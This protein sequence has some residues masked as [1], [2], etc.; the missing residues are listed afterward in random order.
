MRRNALL[1]LIFIAAPVLADFC[2]HT[3]P[4]QAEVAAGGIT[5]I[6]IKAEAGSLKVTG[7]PSLATIRARGTACAS[8]EGL[9]DKT[10]LTAT[11]NGNQLQIVTVTPNVNSS[12]RSARL[13]LVVEVPSGISVDID[14]GSGEIEVH[15]V[16]ALN[17]EDGSGA[18]S[19]ENVRGA[20]TIDDGS[21]D[22]ELENIIGDVSI[23]D[24]S[25]S[26]DVDEIA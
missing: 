14:D 1:G 15:G 19:I 10:R 21:G 26:I 17:V 3:A 8:T 20:V 11:R 22:I 16:G 6:S 7:L 18:L 12:W 5:R 13:D 9:L 23:D 2:D 24:G 25:G 4:R